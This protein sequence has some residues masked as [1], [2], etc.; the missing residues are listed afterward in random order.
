MHGTCLAV[1]RCMHHQHVQPEM[2]ALVHVLLLLLCVQFLFGCV[3]DQ[4]TQPEISV[5]VHVLLPCPQ[6]LRQQQGQL[7][8]PKLIK[9]IAISVARGMAYLH[10][11]WAQCRDLLA[12]WLCS[13]D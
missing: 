2:S 10:S 9:I 4:H 5:D 12:S 6:V 7:L 8:D 13:S 1:F 11:R 3:H